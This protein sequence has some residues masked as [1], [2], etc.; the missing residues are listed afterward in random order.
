MRQKEPLRALSDD[1]RA[2]LVHLSRS[3]REPAAVVARAKAVVAVA[4][5]ANYTAAA[6]AAGRRS[7][8]A[9]G[10]LVARF[11]QAGL[12]G[13]V[14]GHG[15]G[16]PA[17][18]TSAERERMLAEARPPPEQERGGTATR[19]LAPFKRA[20]APPPARLPQSGTPP[21]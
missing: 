17:R 18:Y 13:L 3:A 2:V 5:G 1:E 16:Q 9:V 14:P 7:G 6:H 15:G 10:R 4:D 19:P 11:N 20:V 12:E 8:D 21:P